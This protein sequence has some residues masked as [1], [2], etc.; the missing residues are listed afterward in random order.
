MTTVY[1][2]TDDIDETAGYEDDAWG[3]CDC[4]DCTAPIIDLYC[5]LCNG[6]CEADW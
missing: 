3:E 5:E 6:P 1:C 2:T 4:E